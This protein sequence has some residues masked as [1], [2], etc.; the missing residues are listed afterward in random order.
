MVEEGSEGGGG[1]RNDGDV[2]FDLRPEEDLDCV[3]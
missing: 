2:D 3:V 1:C